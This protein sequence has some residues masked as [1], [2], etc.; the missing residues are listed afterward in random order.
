MARWIGI[1]YGRRRIGVAVSDPLGIS[2]RPLE[3]LDL[4]AGVGGRPG[5]AWR[6]S[7]GALRRAAERLAQ[8]CQEH[9]AQGLVVGEPRDLGGAPAASAAWIAE[10][11]AEL[12][13]ALAAVGL[14]GMAVLRIDER[15]STVG[16]QASLG[17][18]GRRGTAERIRQR[19]S[20]LLDAAAAAVIL[21]QFLSEGGA[22]LP[23]PAMEEEDERHER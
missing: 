1:D 22:A 6:A 11:V 3:T 20:G 21:Q 9:E 13:A 15:G 12:R 18:S 23:S 19:R 10:R 14:G 16:A 7:P 4:A 5:P 2:A 8:L 17:P